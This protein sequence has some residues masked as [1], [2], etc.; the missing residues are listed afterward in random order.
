MHMTENQKIA[1][2]LSSLPDEPGVYQMLDSGGKIIY[3]GK[4]NSLKK[5]VTSYF[6]K[7]D[8]D[9]KTTVLVKNI[10]DIE[11]IIT[12]SEIE[13][14]LLEST[15]IKK[16]KPK[17]NVR[18]KDDKRYP[19]IAVTLN[20]DYPRVI[21]TR[22]INRNK[23]RYFGPFT[24][25]RAAKNTS[26]M[27]NNLFRLKTCRRQIPL[28]ENERPCINYQIGKCSG[29]CDGK[30]SQQEYRALVDD[31][32]SFLEG[33]IEPV[34]ENLNFRMK[35]YS[36]SM[37]F[38][39]AAAMR[40][41]I[42]DI[43]TVSQKQKVDLASGL[44][45][46]YMSV[47]ITGGEAL[48][49]LFEFRRGVLTGRRVNVFDNAE[50]TD[51]GTVFSAFIV[52][53]YR[54][55]EIPS[56]IMTPVNVPD[57]KILAAHL[58]ELAGTKVIITTAASK[59]DQAI[60][61][62]INKNIDIITAERRLSEQNNPVAGLAALKDSLELETEPEVMECFD[63]SNFQ[64]TDAV[65]SMVQFKTG[66]PDKKGYRRYKIRG[67]EQSN[68]PGMIHEAVSRRLQFLV[69]ENLPLPDLVIIDGGPTQLARAIEAAENFA[70]ELKIISLAK[71][72]EE[73]YTD[74]RREPLR[75]PENSPA[76]RLLQNIRDEAH[77]F[78]VTYH[79]KLRD[80]RTIASELDS[81]PDTG[82]KTRLLLLK[83][84]KSVDAVKSATAEELA[85]VPGLGRA[86][87]EKIY[88]YFHS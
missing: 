32:V 55:R 88:R 23:D 31:A 1:Q 46:D 29:V 34:I 37:D 67:Y 40:D 21:Y 86:K 87:A 26:I 83:H 85:A 36:A 50:Y 24:D 14:L 62:L 84:F 28:R 9:P 41:M 19:Y 82:E 25:A 47:K 4:A 11:Y 77:R 12:D 35:A 10:R 30:I 38:E 65:A 51:E 7:K 22:S 59:Q 52:E 20:E 80:K 16:H 3:I 69:N 18:L 8:H 64:G 78:A 74:P 58:S 72:F 75:L 60:I 39:K 79:R 73:I 81:I 43:Q 54:A 45:Q 17:F 68:D 6:T 44:N 5:R 53:Y 33:N 2:I 48:L 57:T 71:R 13:A 76:L 49:V 56:R 42:F 27:I 70:P 63:I 61:S 66:R 15:L